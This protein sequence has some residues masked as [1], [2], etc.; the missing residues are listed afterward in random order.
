MPNRDAIL[1]W[2]SAAS[3]FA[4]RWNRLILCP[5]KLVGGLLDRTVRPQ[6]RIARDRPPPSPAPKSAGRRRD[7]RGLSRARHEARAGGRDKSRSSTSLLGPGTRR[8]GSSARPKMLAVAQPPADRSALRHGARRRSALPRDGADRR[9]DA[10]RS[11]AAR[12]HAG[13]GSADDR[14]CRSPR[15]SRR[16]TKKGSCTAT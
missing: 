8:G 10:R 15:R 6:L 11:A 2:L 9:R 13:R 14:A 5:S 7:G 1:G 3:I 16:R 12:A 4:S